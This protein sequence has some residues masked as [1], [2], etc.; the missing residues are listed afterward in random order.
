MISMRAVMKRRWVQTAA[1]LALALLVAL[2]AFLGVYRPLHLRWGATDAEV[3]RVMPGD[4]IEP[5]PVFNA[6]RAVTINASPEQIWPWI[7]QIGYGKAGWYGLDLLD[8]GGVPSARRIIPELQ[9]LAVGDKLPI[10][11]AVSPSTTDVHHLVTALE[12]GRYLLTHSSDNTTWIW[13]LYPDSAGH[14]RLVWRMRSAPYQWTS[15]FIAA[16]LLT[17]LLDYVAVSE[18]ML[19]IAERVEGRVTPTYVPYVQAGLWLVVFLVYLGAN[20]GIAA[21]RSW[22]R[23]LLLAVAAA[24]VTIALV[25]GRPAL[26]VD[27]VAAIAAC[28]AW[29]WAHGRLPR[30]AAAAP[31]GGSGDDQTPCSTGRTPAD[32]LL[33]HVSG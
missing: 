27:A 26:W 7:V 14:T 31:V 30:R 11:P 6:T 19:G 15:P 5:R 4:D 24:L 32:N 18:N 8:N 17:E 16:Q 9:S 29:A 3:A 13:A 10:F 20:I 12:P 33:P 21:W 2:T 25:L 28:W 23:A 1:R 22:R